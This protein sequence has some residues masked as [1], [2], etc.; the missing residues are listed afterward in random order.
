MLLAE[1]D[2]TALRIAVR[3][4]YIHEPFLIKIGFIIR[5]PRGRLASPEAYRYFGEE[6][7]RGPLGEAVAEPIDEDDGQG[8]LFDE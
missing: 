8:N 7:P 4:Q 3:I 2:E 5:T 6:P 1:G